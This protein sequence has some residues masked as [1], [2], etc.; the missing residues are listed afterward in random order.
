[1]RW[2]NSLA[3]TWLNSLSDN[4]EF[5]FLLGNQGFIDLNN[6]L[7]RFSAEERKRLGVHTCFDRA[8]QSSPRK[9]GFAQ[10]IKSYLGDTGR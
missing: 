10:T 5:P 8:D 7:E 2:H 1:M 9:E 6:L 4:A 3:D